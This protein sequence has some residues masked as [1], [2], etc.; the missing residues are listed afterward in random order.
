M[1]PI[2]EGEE[3]QFEIEDIE[4]KVFKKPAKKELSE[5]QK[6]ALAAGRAKV[7]ERRIAK[8]KENEAIANNVKQKKQAKE[9]AKMTRMEQARSK[10]LTK[11]AQ[12]RKLKF[13][14]NKY[15]IL[16][17]F[18]DEEDFDQFANALD[19]IPEEYFSKPSKLEKYMRDMIRANG[20]TLS[21]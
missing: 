15:R 21:Y 10:V 8:L 17:N 14:T 9:Q 13:D 12:K 5:K 1:E 19:S 16:E 3:L 2:Q 7:K 6:K 11:A 4:E 20:G 18:S